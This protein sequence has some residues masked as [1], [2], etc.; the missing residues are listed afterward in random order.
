MGTV[1]P[2]FPTFPPLYIWGPKYL[3]QSPHKFPTLLQVCPGSPPWGADDACIKFDRN[4]FD[5]KVVVREVK[6]VHIKSI[7]TV[8]QITTAGNNFVM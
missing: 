4:V 1:Y 8:A 5:I 3:S 7:Q 6:A 2:Y